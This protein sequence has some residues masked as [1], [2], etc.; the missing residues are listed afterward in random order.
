MIVALD[1]LNEIRL[2]DPL[3]RLAVVQAGVINDELRQAAAGIGL[4]YPPDTASSPGGLWR[5]DGATK[6][7]GGVK[8]GLITKDYVLALLKMVTRPRAGAPSGQASAAGR[9]P[10][11]PGSA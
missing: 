7:P 4:W 8:H 2:I 11:Q 6:H 1:R 10:L 3:E 5:A 9:G